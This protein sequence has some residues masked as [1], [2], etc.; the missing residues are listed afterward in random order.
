VAVVE[1][2]AR[3]GAAFAAFNQKP[4]MAGPTGPPGLGIFHGTLPALK[5]RAAFKPPPGSD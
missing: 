4:A 1:M 3:L 2:V 5:C